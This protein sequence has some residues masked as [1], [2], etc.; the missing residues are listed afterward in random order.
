MPIDIKGVWLDD[1]TGNIEDKTQRPCFNDDWNWIL[2]E[3]EDDAW[4]WIYEGDNDA[5]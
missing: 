5:D 3:D 1:E 2:D 4:D